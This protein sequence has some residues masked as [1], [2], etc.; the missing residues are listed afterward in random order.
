MKSIEKNIS[1]TEISV[2][3]PVVEYNDKLVKDMR[4]HYKN[5]N[6]SALDQYI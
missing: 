4:E 2:L 1:K 3:K 5:V 6:C